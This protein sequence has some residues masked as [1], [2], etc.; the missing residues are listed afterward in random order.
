MRWKMHKWQHEI[1]FF[2]IRN[3]SFR[4]VD[5][6][7]M[8]FDA[9]KKCTH[10]KW[11]SVAMPSLSHLI[12]CLVQPASFWVPCIMYNL[13]LHIMIFLLGKIIILC[14]KNALTFFCSVLAINCDD[15]FF[16]SISRK[17]NPKQK[18][19]MLN[20]CCWCT[21]QNGKKRMHRLKQLVNLW[22]RF[23]LLGAWLTRPFSN[24][25]S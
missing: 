5:I 13:T 15:I 6:V 16:Y 25:F 20:G 9:L 11:E 4:C 21:K 14:Q 3:C 7:C 8:W 2:F 18:K 1:R 17:T 19:N 24:R 23:D 22:V 12:C 10:C